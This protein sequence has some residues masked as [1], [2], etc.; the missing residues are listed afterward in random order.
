MV[1]VRPSLLLLR[2]LLSASPILP[3]LGSAQRGAVL[4]AD[5]VGPHV[6][7]RSIE[8]KVKVWSP[9]AILLFCFVFCV[10]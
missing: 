9:L 6:V 2:M 4:G 8:E 7:D 10:G 1:E 5:V 3:R